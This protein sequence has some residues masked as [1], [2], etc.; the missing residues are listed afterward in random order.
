MNINYNL[1]SVSCQKAEIN[2][3]VLGEVNITFPEGKILSL[4]KKPNSGYDYE[5]GKLN[6]FKRK[7]DM[8]LTKIN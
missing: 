2:F 8:Y 4:N 5:V 7:K 3:E 6:A 1:F